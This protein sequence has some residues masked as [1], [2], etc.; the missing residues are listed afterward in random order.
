[1]QGIVGGTPGRGQASD[2]EREIK[3]L[4]TRVLRLDDATASE[5]AADTPLFDDG[6]GFDSIDALQ[7]A[8]AIERAYSVRIAPDDE[9]NRRILTS[10]RSL[11]SY[12]R[13][14]GRIV[15]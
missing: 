3:D 9:A 6:L 10:V 12:V 5:I 4:I 14:A 1:M 2:L 11:A 15:R 13:D 7:V 8:V